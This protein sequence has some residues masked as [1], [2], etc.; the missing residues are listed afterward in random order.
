[1]N[2]DELKRLIEEQKRREQEELIRLRQEEQQRALKEQFEKT[3]RGGPTDTRPSE[4]D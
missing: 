4:D 3:H 2:Q 1:M